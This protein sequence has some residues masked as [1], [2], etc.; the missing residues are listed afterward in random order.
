MNNFRRV[1]ICDVNI[2]KQG[3]YIGFDQ[4][5]INNFSSVE[6][7]NP[8]VHISFLF[9]HEAEKLLQFDN[10]SKE[11]VSFID[12]FK[13]KRAVEKYLIIRKI[14]KF[15]EA[16]HID[17]MLFMDLDQYQMPLFLVKLKFS[18]S[19]ILF[20]PHH[21]IT[22]SNNRLSTRVMS[23]LKRLKKRI[24]EKM[25]TTKKATRNIF[26]LNDQEGV[27]ILNRI[28]HSTLFK[29]LPDPVF[30]YTNFESCTHLPEKN[31]GVYRYL[32]F[33]S[34]N[35]RKNIFNIIQAYDNASLPFDS[36]LL[37]VGPAAAEYIGYLKN[38]ISGLVSIDDHHKKIWIKSE[39]VTN[40]EMDHFFSIC[41]VCLLIYKDFFG[42]SGLLGR[43]ALH[44]LKVIGPSTGLLHELI[45]NYKMGITSDP[46][47]I[48]KIARSMENIVH[49]KIN[50]SGLENFYAQR[51]P[52]KFLATLAD[53]IIS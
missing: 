11:R 45:S 9:N 22:A 21:R 16:N 13:E 14:K 31:H 18:I 49:F 42:S 48:H 7:Q 36:E 12:L 33:G 2:K 3:H 37:I 44:R 40:E 15:A 25:M 39:F 53:I 46:A 8:S 38:G 32:I 52:E 28:H 51:S 29:Y 47:N 34:I 4:Y 17:H 10:L 27:N 26:I 19:G 1:L 30:S 43:A 20:R 23:Q 6:K 41:D 5:L 24:A 35:E 50:M